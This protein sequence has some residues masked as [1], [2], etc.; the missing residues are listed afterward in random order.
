MEEVH[1]PMAKHQQ[2]DREAFVDINPSISVSIYI[3]PLP[4]CACVI[5]LSSI[6]LHTTLYYVE[7]RSLRTT[8]FM[9]VTCIIL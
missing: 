3:M 4:E 7:S 9:R 2:E 8:Y 6:G 5:I 1:F